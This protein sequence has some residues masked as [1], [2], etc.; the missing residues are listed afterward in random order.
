MNLLALRRLWVP[1]WLL[2]SVCLQ[3]TAGAQD[4]T[5]PVEQPGAEGSSEQV[6]AEEADFRRRMELGDDEDERD[7]TDV[8]VSTP[9]GTPETTEPDDRLPE[10]SRE[11]LKEALRDVIAEVGRWEP[12]DAQAEYPYEPS[13]AAQADPQLAAAEA[14]EWEKMVEAYH[15]RERAAWQA[16][17]GTAAGTGD[18][19]GTGQ[20]GETGQGSG[21]EDGS[22]GTDDPGEAGEPGQGAGAAEDESD[23]GDQ[24]SFNALDYIREILGGGA[25]STDPSQ[26][27][28]ENPAPSSPSG[29]GD[30]S[31]LPG[32]AENAGPTQQSGEEETPQAE[33]GSKGDPVA[34][35]AEEAPDAPLQVDGQ[36]PGADSPTRS[37]TTESITGS[38]P[39]PVGSTAGNTD[40][41]PGASPSDPSAGSDASTGGPESAS[42]SSHAERDAAPPSSGAPVGQAAERALPPPGSLP[43]ADLDHLVEGLI[44]ISVPEEAPDEQAEPAGETDGDRPQS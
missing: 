23:R 15:Q 3:G 40:S 38:P 1:A 11:H 4:P 43:V 35:S 26:G 39:E 17:N 33:E 31:E 5:E 29:E 42:G 19:G 21:S 28:G 22:G 32:Q 27:D 24:G 2:L 37:N 16:A 12:A 30:E 18:M 20:A 41:E 36:S 7:I 10:S 34:A 14:A 8:S 9:Y 44:L 25:P 6:D 13:E